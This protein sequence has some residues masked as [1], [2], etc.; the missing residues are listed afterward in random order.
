MSADCRARREPRCSGSARGRSNDAVTP[1]AVSVATADDD[2]HELELIGDWCRTQLEQDPE[3][4]LLI[5]DAKLRQ[6]RRQYERLLSQ[7][8]SP[9]E[10][11]A[12]DARAFSTFFSIE[13]GQPLAEFPAD[14]ACIDDAA[15]AHRRLCASTN[16]CCG[17]G[18]PSSS[19]TTCSPARAIEAL[20]RE[21]HKLEFSAA[22]LAARL[23]RAAGRCRHGRW[24]RDCA[25]RLALL[26]SE[27]RSA[28]DWA[29][30]L[31]AALRAVGWHGSRPL[32]SDEQQTVNRWYALLDEYAALGSWLPRRQRRGSRSD[33][34]RPGP[35]A[36]LRP[37]QRRGSGDADRLARRSDRRATTAS[38][39]PASTRR[40]GR[41]RRDPMSSFRCAC[42]SRRAFPAASAA[43]QSAQARA[44]L[45]A[46]R[47]HARTGVL[48]GAARRRRASHPESAAGTRR[49]AA[50]RLRDAASPVAAPLAAALR[51][52][53][54]EMIDDSH[55]P[56]VN[57]AVIV[58]GGVKPLTLQAECGFHAYGEVRLRARAPR[59][60][61]ARHRSARSRHVAAQGARAGVEQARR[62]ISNL[63]A[64]ATRWCASRPSPGRRCRR[65]LA[66]VSRRTCRSELRACGRARTDAARAAHRE[67]ARATNSTRPT[68][69]SRR[70]SKRA[71]RCN[72]AGGTFDVRIDRIDSLRGR[73]LRHPRLQI[74]RGA[75][76]ALGLTSALRD[77]QLLAYLLAERGRDVQAL[78]NVSLTRGRARFVGKAARKAC[79]RT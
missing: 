12:R 75:L 38:G 60:A 1:A 58:R 73:R 32:R 65:G 22:A 42:R 54:L 71:A 20:L 6:R 68:F 59:G 48:L 28:P 61:G 79:C 9:S 27:P 5:V 43:G 10:W 35:R 26:G 47:A 24:P 16:W 64:A 67:P 78:A 44:S 17:C 13:G 72:I 18:C 56:P 34:G 55:G 46:W 15:P 53:Q 74:R 7:T 52:P 41:R 33:A 45:A 14:R 11:V 49:C 69:D 25:R 29:A 76:A 62:P 19:R 70:D 39:W 2:E 4:R 8:L 21:G 50:P 51:A 36:Q 31:L 77:P 3:R 57:T 40:S 63:I 23:E 66:R 30:R 37:G